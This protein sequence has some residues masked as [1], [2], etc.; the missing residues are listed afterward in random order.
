MGTTRQ[1]VR[2]A[3]LFLPPVHRAVDLARRPQADG[4]RLPVI[5][6][7]RHPR[8]TSGATN[9]RGTARAVTI[10]PL[11]QHRRGTTSETT[12]PPP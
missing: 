1:L 2:R 9:H 11:Y 8:R 10:T 6:I 5:P 4:P 7:W 3:R 12:F